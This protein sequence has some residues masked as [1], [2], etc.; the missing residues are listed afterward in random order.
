[1]TLCL[2]AVN[3]RVKIKIPVSEKFGIRSFY[4]TERK[5]YEFCCKKNT[6]L[7]MWVSLFNRKMF[8]H[9]QCSLYHTKLYLNPNRN[10]MWFNIFP[11]LS[12][13]CQA[14]QQKAIRLFCPHFCLLGSLRF[15][16]LSIYH[17]ACL[18]YQV[19]NNLDPSAI[20]S[21]LAPLYMDI[22][23]GIK[24]SLPGRSEGLKQPS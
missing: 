6:P 14:L 17:N 8:L 7:N 15:P 11:R 16:E 23:P 19:M 2:H 22:T 12:K 4:M 18:L 9:L 1:M 20:L 13:K 5:S 24:T 21:L 10:G 3:I